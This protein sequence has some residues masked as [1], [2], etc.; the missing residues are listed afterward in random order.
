MAFGDIGGAV[1][2]LI[3]TCKTPATGDVDI[4]KGDA[5]KLAGPYT[6]TN[7]TAAED[8]VFGQAL[9]AATT[10]G[11]AIPVRIRGICIFAYTGTEP[12]V[13]GAAGI[14][15]SDTAGVVKTPASGN[16]KGLNVKSDT[17]AGEVHV[18][19]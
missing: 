4:A 9:A 14:V 2:E 16:G 8:P 19:L 5:V 6:V 3:V 10:N 15:A 17:A 1:T 7:A 11:V 12:A 18:L 13:D